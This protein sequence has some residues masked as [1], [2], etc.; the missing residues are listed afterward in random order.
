MQ[1]ENL[2]AARVTLIGIS[3]IGNQIIRFLDAKKRNS[4]LLASQLF[5]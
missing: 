5:Q 1:S 2:R 4:Y 3:F